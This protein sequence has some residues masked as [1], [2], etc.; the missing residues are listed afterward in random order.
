MR[1]LTRKRVAHRV[2]LFTRGPKAC[3]AC[4]WVARWLA[5]RNIQVTEV[6]ISA[7]PAASERLRMLTNDELPVPTILLEDGELIVWPGPGTLEALF[8]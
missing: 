7:S 6:D 8:S 2:T 4:H 1:L 3:A 5:R